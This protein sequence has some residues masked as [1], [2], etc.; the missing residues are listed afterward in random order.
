M[1]I[2]LLQYLGWII[3][4]EKSDLTP[5][6]DFQF[7]GMQFTPQ[8]FTM[9]PLPHMRLR[10]QSV[11]Q[12]WMT[13]PVITAPNLHRLLGMVVFKAALVQWGRLRLR[14]VQWWATTAW[15]QMTRSCSNRITVPLWVLS[16]VAWWSSPA[17]LQGL[18]LASRKNSLHG[19]VQM[20]LGIITWLCGFWREITSVLP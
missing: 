18:P 3:S 1:T 13:N 2:R 11:H 19:Y 4:L 5:S 8:Q 6:H 15:C 20:R 17:V 12:H 7:I 10:V 16:E 9:A 14:P